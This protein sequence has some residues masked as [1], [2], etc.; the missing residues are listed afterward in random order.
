MTNDIDL[1]ALFASA[2]KLSSKSLKAAHTLADED[3]AV[4]YLRVSDER[5]V[6]TSYDPLG[7]SIP[8]QREAIQ[9]CANSRKLRIIR[10]HIDPGKSGKYLA[11]RSEFQ[12]LMNTLIRQRDARYI[13]VYAFN[14]GMRNV[15]DNSVVDMILRQLGVIVI[16]ATEHVGNADTPVDQMVRNTI[17]VQN[18]FYSDSSGADIKTKMGFKARQGGTINRAKLGYLNTRDELPDGR[19]VNTITVDPERAH[20]VT[21]AFELYATGRHT[22]DDVREILT[23]RGLLTRRTP[24]HPPKPVSLNKISLMLRDRYYCGYVTYDGVEYQGWHEP[25]VTEELFERVQRIRESRSTNNSRRRVHQHHLKGCLWCPRCKRR[26]II[27]RANGNGGQYFYYFCIGREKKTCDMPYLRIDGRR[28][29][30]EA[31]S[32]HLASI[33][34]DEDTRHA[35]AALVTDALTNRPDTDDATRAALGKRLDEL[36]RQE[37]NLYSLL[38]SPDWDRDRATQEMR[39]VRQQKAAAQRELEALNHDDQHTDTGR[40]LLTHALDLLARPGDIYDYGNDTTKTLLVKTIFAKLHL[41]ITPDN[42][43]TVSDTEH[44]EPFDVLD[45]L[46]TQHR[47]AGTSEPDHGHLITPATTRRGTR[48]PQR[49]KNARG[50]APKNHAPSVSVKGSSKTRYVELRGL[51]PLTPSLP[52]AQ[53]L[54]PCGNGEN[55][56]KAL[57]FSAARCSLRPFVTSLCPSFAPGEFV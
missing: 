43:A 2:V 9:G 41:E 12:D 40:E 36:T 46:A 13:I 44:A 35:V 20:Y 53:G 25:L 42:A 17:A 8:T 48:Q 54:S 18:Q 51:E 33:A 38:S 30:E 39:T 45:Q 21:Q 31:V 4:A 32:R 14:R 24:A 56:G 1:E 28:G 49:R 10:W 6:K 50:V 47:E 22:E 7:N 19:K 37:D 57:R 52:G 26:F 27:A 23:N 29:V 16:S 5:Q 3:A 15:I 34:L 11:Q 55:A